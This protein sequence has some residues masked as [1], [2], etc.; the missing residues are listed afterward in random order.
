MYLLLVIF[1]SGKEVAGK[2][3]LKHIYEIARVKAEDPAFAGVPL[4]SICRTI[5][6]SARSIGI[7]VVR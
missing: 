6:G 5:I 2:V 4:E 3:T 7:Q 1:F